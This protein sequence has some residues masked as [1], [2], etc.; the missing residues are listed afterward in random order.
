MD[1]SRRPTARLASQA[2]DSTRCCKGC[3]VHL[4]RILTRRDE[5]SFLKCGALKVDHHH[6]VACHTNYRSHHTMVIFTNGIKYYYY[7]TLFLPEARC[8]C[9]QAAV[10]AAKILPLDGLARSKQDPINRGH[11]AQYLY[12]PPSAGA[13]GIKYMHDISYHCHYHTI[14]ICSHCMI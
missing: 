8:V 5:G 14:I 9:R 1:M 4:T 11:G 6:H 12:R 10:K 13:N 7:Y 3:R 2:A